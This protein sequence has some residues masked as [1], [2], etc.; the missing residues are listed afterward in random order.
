MWEEL[1]E[2]F[3]LVRS[4][5]SY[6]LAANV[7]VLE[8]QGS[9]ESQWLGQRNATTSCTAPAAITVLDGEA[10]ND[11]LVGGAGSDTYLFSAGFGHDVIEDTLDY[12]ENDVPIPHSGTDIIAFDSRPSRRP[13]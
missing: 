12:D 8:L 4:S 10:G 9:G 1:N 3:D 13:T 11:Y 6:K 7:E 2:G 5:V